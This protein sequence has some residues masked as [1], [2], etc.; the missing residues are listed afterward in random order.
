MLV[1]DIWKIGAAVKDWRNAEVVP[2][3]KKGYLK[4]CDNWRGDSRFDVV[5][6]L[7]GG[8]CKTGYK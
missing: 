7:F 4:V 3:L 8:C 2:I 1:E 6:E 5:G